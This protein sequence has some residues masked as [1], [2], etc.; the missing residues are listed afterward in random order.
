MNATGDP[1]RIVVR[2]VSVGKVSFGSSWFVVMLS[3][4]T[5]LAPLGIDTSLPALPMMA[6][7]LHT[8]DGVTQATLGAF[9]LAFALGQLVVGP[10]S[11]RYGRR[12]VIIAGMAVF[13]L[14]GVLCAAATNGPLLVAA[15]FS[16]GFGACAGAVVG[17]AMI[18]D[19]FTERTRAATMQA[20]ASAISGVVP[21]LAPLLGA[22]LLPLGWR[23]IYVAL[24]AGGVLLLIAT[25]IWLPESLTKRAASAN[26]RHIFERYGQ[27]L[28]LPRSLA[29]CA[30]VACSFAGMFAFISGSP[31]VL[32]RELGLSNLAYG[33]A[34]AISSGSI[35]AGSWMSGI[36][37][38]RIGSERLL[39][40][41]CAAAAI[42]GCVTFALGV[43]EPHAPAA[44]EFVGVMAAYAF[45]FGL[46]APNAFA[47]GMEHAGAMAGVAAGMLGA[48]QMLG[49]SV[50]SMVNGALPFKTYVDV[51]LTV[52]V[53]GIGV[54]A[55]Y[56][57]SLRAGRLASAISFEEA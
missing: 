4:I 57:W 10:L 42:V 37:A 39:S 13:A 40:A 19:V 11:D 7:A 35:L 21:M 30:V 56:L 52:G 6:R 43:L 46:I 34:F 27:F 26:I 50:G 49:G 2:T 24:I 28:A 54:A 1:V 20:Y 3:A 53:A 44:W 18:R 12:P 9:M 48:T 8:S 14:A 38:H 51:G 16:Q 5:A 15:R 22:A 17:R 31:F 25:T 45:T 41:G 32:V 33:I 55:A 47:A 29:L 23:A 36:L